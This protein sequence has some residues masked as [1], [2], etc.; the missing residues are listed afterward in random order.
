MSEPTSEA[1]APA[2]ERDLA[3]LQGEGLDG[4]FARKWSTTFESITVGAPE[5]ARTFTLLKPSNADHLISE[6]DYVMDE[7]LPYWADLWPSARV[8]AGALLALR[9]EGRTLLEMGCGLGLDTTAAMAAGFDVTATDYYEDAIHMARGNAA[10]N[11][12]HEPHVRMVNWRHWPADLGTFDVVIAAD[13]L[14]EKEYASLVGACL[15][16][17]LAPTGVAIVA[18]PGRLALP[19]FRDHLP[20]VGLELIRT[21]V[22]PFEEGAVKQSVQLLHLQ[23]AR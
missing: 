4:A 23:H 8:L 6:A 13:V 9:G 5:H 20:E 12:G 1:T 19:A 22:V 15:A 14:Y 21:D 16:R 17:A 10:R 18:D 3:A 11:L 7:R 2:A